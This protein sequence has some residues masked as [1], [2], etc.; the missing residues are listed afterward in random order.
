[1]T[2]HDILQLKGASV[3][4]IFPNATLQEVSEELVRRS[5]GALLVCSRDAQS[6]EQVLGIITERD[7]LH[8][9][10]S[11]RG[12]LN[13]VSAGEA[14]SKQLFT[15]T[16]TDS[17]E[18]VMGLMTQRRIRHVP[19]MLGG[20]LV[21]LVSIG[22]VVKSQY[23]RLAMENQFMKNYIADTPSGSL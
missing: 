9:C 3:F 15:A 16:P 6:G 18:D 7:I 2:I 14:M 12:P 5:I 13:T 11:G 10:A 19:V 20:R 1:M 21:G 22:D 23:D 17:V 4:T 8:V